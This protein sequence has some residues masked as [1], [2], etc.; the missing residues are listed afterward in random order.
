MDK[1]D[2]IVTEPD[3]ANDN[4]QKSKNNENE[5]NGTNNDDNAITGVTGNEIKFEGKKEKKDGGN[6]MEDNPNGK[7]ENDERQ[8]STTLA[9]IPEV[10]K[11][12]ASGS[13]IL[14]EE[15]EQLDGNSNM[16]EELIRKIEELENQ[17]KALKQRQLIK[18]I[19]KLQ[20]EVQTNYED[21]TKCPDKSFKASD[22][23][24]IPNSEYISKN[25]RLGL[26]CLTPLSKNISVILW[27]SVLLVEYT[28]KSTYLSQV[29][30]KLYYI[31]LYRVHLALNGVRTH[32]FSG[33]RH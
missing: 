17:K 6:K 22:E 23:P 20:T 2:S 10:G 26:W 7:K 25:V 12:H 19:E 16:R 27:R 33:D 5:T 13:I 28:A 24:V 21:E 18:E 15:T 4:N 32:K 29:T 14:N 31:M 1:K 30:D 8:S 9:N 3:A 11:T